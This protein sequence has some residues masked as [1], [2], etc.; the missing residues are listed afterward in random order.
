[1]IDRQARLE[2]FKRQAAL[3]AVRHVRSGMT[4]GLGT[5]STARHAILEI[6][7][8]VQEGK[9]SEII[10][11]PTSL[12]SEQLARDVGIEV[13][14][15]S[16]FGVDLAIDGAD[17]IAPNLD[18]IKGHGGALVREK[19]VEFHARQFIVV[20]DTSKLVPELCS[21]VTLPVEILRWGARATV[22]ALAEVQNGAQ[23]RLRMQDGEPAV[24]DNGNLIADIRF[25][26]P[27]D[28]PREMDARIRHVPGVVD[29]GF[30][31]GYANL[32]YV[33]GPNGVE[34]F[35]R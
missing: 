6:G 14:E 33:A 3:E 23:V 5:G 26:F 19:L 21:R 4:L 27:V 35:S 18:L 11:V 34:K 20:A 31:L 15:L 1:M 9:L 16:A 8:L 2:E 7:R 30:F 22:N 13:R 17:E 29:S 25:R 28:N 24:S 32:A 10:G 12:A